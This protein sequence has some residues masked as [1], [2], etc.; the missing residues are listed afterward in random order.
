[1]TRGVFAGR[2]VPKVFEHG[3]GVLSSAEQ[4]VFLLRGQ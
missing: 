4:S 2:I 3:P 1:M